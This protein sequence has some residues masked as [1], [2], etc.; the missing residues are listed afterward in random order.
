MMKEIL[1][2]QYTLPECR[3]YE[4]HLSK[5]IA[6]SGGLNDFTEEDLSGTGWA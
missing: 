1:K 6:T 2:D 4:V 5:V 3:V